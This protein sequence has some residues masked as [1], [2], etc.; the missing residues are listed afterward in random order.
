M[1]VIQGYIGIIWGL[2]IGI[3]RDYMG[4]IQGYIGIIWGLYIGIYR[5]YM[6]VGGASV[7]RPMTTSDFP[8]AIKAKS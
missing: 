1:G 5:D 7:I 6:G 3:Y 8:A 4:V 2:Y